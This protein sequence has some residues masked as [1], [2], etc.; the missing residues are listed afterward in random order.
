VTQLLGCGCRRKRSE[1]AG[2]SVTGY[3]QQRHGL[4]FAGAGTLDALKQEIDDVWN[5]A[6]DAVLRVQQLLL[7]RLASLKRCEQRGNDTQLT[8]HLC[9]RNLSGEEKKIKS[10]EESGGVQNE[11]TA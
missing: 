9:T 8:L 10:I 7:F 5:N 4:L 1:S 2:D 3:L 11:R 6:G